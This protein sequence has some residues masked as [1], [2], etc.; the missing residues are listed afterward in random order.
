[1]QLPYRRILLKIEVALPS[2]EAG[3]VV[4]RKLD[5]LKNLSV[6]AQF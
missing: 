1:M 5:A 6:L 2:R 4:E 3:Q